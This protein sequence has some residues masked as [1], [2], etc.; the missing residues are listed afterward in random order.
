MKKK[1]TTKKKTVARSPRL[2][3]AP[4]ALPGITVRIY[5]DLAEF[6]LRLQVTLLDAMRRQDDA[7]DP[8]SFEVTVNTQ[9]GVR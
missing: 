2:V 1:P 7:G 9:P 5:R 3:T 4:T 6:H 8:V